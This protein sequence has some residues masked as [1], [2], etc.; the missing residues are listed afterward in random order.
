MN[1]EMYDI[2]LKPA[3]AQAYTHTYINAFHQK[4]WTESEIWQIVWFSGQVHATANSMS[5]YTP[6]LKNESQ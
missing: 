4:R 1:N 5:L 2:P 3:K 6:P